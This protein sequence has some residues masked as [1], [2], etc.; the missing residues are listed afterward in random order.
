MGIA[1]R[2]YTKE[3]RVIEVIE[4]IEHD[5]LARPDR[6][7]LAELLPEFCRAVRSWVTAVTESPAR[8]VP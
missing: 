3:I 7:A 5:H 4:V 2:L 1:V 6:K 8:L